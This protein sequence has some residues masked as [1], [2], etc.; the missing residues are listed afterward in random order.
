MTKNIWVSLG[1][2]DDQTPI[3]Y[4]VKT[5]QWILLEKDFS[6]NFTVIIFS[7]C[8]DPLA[9]FWDSLYFYFVWPWFFK[10]EGF[11]MDMRRMARLITI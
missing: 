9:L 7:G 1:L 11:T 2:L 3:D 10:G 5:K 4:L 8:E 6:Y